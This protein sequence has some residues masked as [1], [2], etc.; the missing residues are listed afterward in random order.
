MMLQILELML[1]LFDDEVDTSVSL[2]HIVDAFYPL[3][4]MMLQR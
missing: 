1:M 2:M 4:M 3:M